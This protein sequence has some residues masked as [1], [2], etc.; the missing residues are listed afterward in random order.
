MKI[1]ALL[2]AHIRSSAEIMCAVYNNEHWQAHWS[3]ETAAEYLRD[4]YDAP[5]FCGFAAVE[6]EILLG[7]VC[8]HEKVWWNKSEIVVEELFVMPERQ[9]KGIGSALLAAVED[10]ARERKLAGVTL[11]TNSLAPAAKFYSHR[12][13]ERNESVICMYKLTE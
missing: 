1:I 13:Y 10:L 12:G 9:G 7:A 11:S 4:F 2:P 8:C 6:G 5:K 3:V